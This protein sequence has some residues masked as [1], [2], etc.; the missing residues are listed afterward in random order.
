MQQIVV[1][2]LLVVLTALLTG[3]GVYL[4]YIHKMRVQ[5]AQVE[6]RLKHLEEEVVRVDGRVDSHSGKI[7]AILDGI[8]DI[9]V[10]IAKINTT[11]SIIEK[12]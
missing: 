2:V 11:L 1:D 7:D 3:V 5:V 4:G 12:G 6:V 8:S 9:K 10:S